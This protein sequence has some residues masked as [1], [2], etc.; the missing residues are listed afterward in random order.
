MFC[1]RIINSYTTNRC[2][3]CFNLFSVLLRFSVA[4]YFTI[5]PQ[6]LFPIS[7]MYFIFSSNYFCLNVMLDT[8]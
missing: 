5:Y 4:V 6:V 7:I 2:K 8:F 1:F 3:Y